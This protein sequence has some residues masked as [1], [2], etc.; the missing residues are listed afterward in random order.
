MKMIIKNGTVI[1]PIS[2]TMQ[3]KDLYVQDG[4]FLTP[5]GFTV[6]EADQI[7]DANQMWVMPGFVD[8]HVHLR[9]PGFEHKETIETGANAAARGGF[10]RILAMPN[11]K[12]VTGT[13]QIVEYIKEKASL[14]PI[15]VEIVGAITKDQNGQELT[16]IQEMKDAGILAI[17]EDGKSVADAG[18]YRDA[19]NKAAACQIPVLAHC[20]DVK[21]MNGGYVNAD[22]DTAKFGYKG[23]TN[24]VEDVI[25]A[26]D[27]VLAKET[28][29]KLHLC[30]CSTK[31]SVEMVRLAKEAGIDVTAEV[32]PHHFVLSSNDLVAGDTNYKMN[33]PL[34]TTEDV[35]AL[36]R[37]LSLN[38]MDVIA[39]DHAPHSQEEKNQSME[40]APFGIVGLETAASL[41]Y[42][43][44]VKPGHLSP[45]QMAEKMSTNP[46]K[47]IGK[48]FRGFV[49]GEVADLVIF[50]PNAEYVIQS[51]D[52][53]SKGKNTPF[54]GWSVQGRVQYTICD[55][56]VV[57]DQSKELK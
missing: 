48:P 15:H 1:D 45:M 19:M 39:T 26:R 16:P 25:I 44:L 24:S 8:L 38:I 54:E 23:I 46:S 50:D 7:I 34:R 9:E 11:T 43:Y 20:E 37:G 32:C 14:A 30:H 29:A 10:T 53:A 47:V 42:Q 28:G 40:K 51:K 2:G 17:S 49:E 27:L 56:K 31:D 6:E 36:I 57:F 12:P 4:Q 35:E 33:P 55:G 22:H 18:L 21:L 41:V 5:S 3:V 13:V 52:F